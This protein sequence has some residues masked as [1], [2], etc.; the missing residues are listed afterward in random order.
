MAAVDSDGDGLSDALEQALLEQ[1]RPQFMIGR[2]DCAKVPAE[3][4]AGGEDAK[5]EGAE[6]N[7]LRAGVSGGRFYG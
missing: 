5:G 3:F 4:L 1:F 7:D 2:G 6:R